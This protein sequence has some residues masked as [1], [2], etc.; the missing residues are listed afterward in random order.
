MHL[1][2]GWLRYDDSKVCCAKQSEV[3][4][5]T[6]AYILFYRRR[7]IETEHQILGS[8]NGDVCNRR[9]L[10][11]FT[12]MSLNFEEDVIA[13]DAT[14]NRSLEQ[15]TDLQ[16]S[17]RFEKSSGSKNL[18]NDTPTKLCDQVEHDYLDNSDP[19]VTSNFN[20]VETSKERD[21]RKVF[22]ENTNVTLEKSESDSRINSDVKS[23]EFFLED[24]L[25]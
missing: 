16:P 20:Q 17:S 7:A 22:Y 12:E 25:D 13:K 8:I 3:E 10:K 1:L 24:I 4:A 19:S 14:S 15:S 18:P 6:Q 5:E 2:L 9:K 23:S 11:N 21:N